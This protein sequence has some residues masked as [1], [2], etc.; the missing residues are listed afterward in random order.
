VGVDSDLAE[1]ILVKVSAAGDGVLPTKASSLLTV[2]RAR[3]KPLELSFTAFDGRKIDLAEL[4]GKVVMLD[5][6]ATW[7]PPCREAT[8]EIVGVYRRLHERGFEIVG[9]SLDEGKAELREYLLQH[10]M[11]WPQYF[12]GGG[13]N[14]KLAQKYEI[15]SIPSVWLVNKAGYLVDVEGRDDLEGKVERLLAE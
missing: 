3:K 5:F 10:Q 13:W 12:D 8:P 2:L 14:N 7:C 11:T 4:R 15:H 9:I 1:S 6:W